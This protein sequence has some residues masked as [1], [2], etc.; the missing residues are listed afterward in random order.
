MLHSKVAIKRL[1]EE[2]N[3]FNATS[4]TCSLTFQLL[5][6]VEAFTVNGRKHTHTY[7]AKAVKN[8]LEKYFYKFQLIFS[9]G[10]HL[11]EF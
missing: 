5:Q 4:L 2:R 3:V 10:V 7:T 11:L 9:G 6:T 1:A 8:F